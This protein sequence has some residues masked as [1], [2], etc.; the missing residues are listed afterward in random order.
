MKTTL[1]ISSLR[2]SLFA[3]AASVMLLFSGCSKDEAQVVD[4]ENLV[5][6]N[7]ADQT[8]ASGPSAS[9]HGTVS[10]DGIPIAGEGFRQFS[11]HA[12][13]KNNGSVDG[14]GVLSYTGGEL[15]IKFDIDCLEVDGNVAIMSGVV[16]R[17]NQNPAGEGL[18]CWF[19]VID[20][21]EGANA[22]PDQISLFFSGT[23]PVVLTCT[24]N[25]TV[26][27]YDIEGGNVQVRE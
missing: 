1:R 9:G 12:R 21:G 6:T 22:A 27:I 25:L 13:V 20:N 4:N 5:V 18:L 15:N 26:D 10:F 11:F 19:K 7:D 17:N 24:N 3:V 2:F 16:T 14:S 23:N 8:R